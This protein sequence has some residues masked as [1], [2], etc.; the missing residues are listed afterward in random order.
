MKRNGAFSVYSCMKIWKKNFKVDYLDNPTLSK[1]IL[2]NTSVK[3]MSHGSAKHKQVIIDS[4]SH[5]LEDCK[6]LIRVCRS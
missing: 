6:Q 3:S 2:I 5:I 1:S 4:A